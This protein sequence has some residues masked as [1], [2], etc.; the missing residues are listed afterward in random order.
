VT[1][2]LLYDLAA[3]GGDGIDHGG[4]PLGGNRRPA[5]LGGLVTQARRA[6]EPPAAT[7]RQGR[8]DGPAPVRLPHGGGGRRGLVVIGAPMAAVGFVPGCGGLGPARRLGGVVVAALV[9]RSRRRE[10]RRFPRCATCGSRAGDT[11]CRGSPVRPSATARAPRMFVSGPARRERQV[12]QPALDPDE[13]YVPPSVAP[14]GPCGRRR[15]SSRPRP[16]RR[17]QRGPVVAHRGRRDEDRRGD[18]EPGV[19]PPLASATRGASR[20]GRGTRER[21]PP[22]VV[23]PL[24]ECSRWMLRPCRRR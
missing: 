1:T 24:A 18:V 11:T 7:G 15:G 20:A 9:V 16:P 14:S 2:S 19:Q 6:A 8:L 3:Q 23:L 10:R 13:R 4:V 17:S 21:L 22:E 5:G 12:V